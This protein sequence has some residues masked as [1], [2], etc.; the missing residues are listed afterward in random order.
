MKKPIFNVKLFFDGIKQLRLACGVLL[1]ISIA[2]SVVPAISS[3]MHYLD[4][5][6]QLK[7]FPI[8]SHML[9]QAYYNIYTVTLINVA[10]VLLILMYIAPVILCSLS[11]IFSTNAKVRIFITL[12][13][14]A[15]H[16]Y[17]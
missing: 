1:I 17:F 12:C 3:L 7:N 14:R 8:S 10:P 15:E 9:L 6:A 16:P 13:L 4:I 11:L 5:N 2:A